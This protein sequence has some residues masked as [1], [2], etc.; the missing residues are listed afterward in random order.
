MVKKKL[1]IAVIAGES[2]GDLIASRL[3]KSLQEQYGAI[4]FF[5]V[6]GEKMKA[7][8]LLEIFPM[9]DINVMGLVEVIPHIIT[10]AKRLNQA[11]EF[12]LRERPDAVITVDAPGFNFRLAKKIR[13][14]NNAIKLIHY[15]APTVWAWKPGRAKKIAKIY[16]HLL[17]LFSF[18]PPYFT[19][20]GLS[21]TFV[22]HPLSEDDWQ[23][24]PFGKRTYFTLLPGSRIAEVEK[25][26]PL[27]KEV[28]LHFKTSGL[29]FVLP[30]VEHL[31]AQIENEVKT[32]GCDV[33]VICDEIQ[34]KNIFESSRIAL[35]ASG[36]VSLELACAKT[37]MVICYRVSKFTEILARLL[38]KTKYFCLVNI[39]N[40]ENVVA[41][42]LQEKCNVKEICDEVSHLLLKENAVA[43]VEKFSLTMEKIKPPSYLEKGSSFLAAQSVL[44]VVL[45]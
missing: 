32:W 31:K 42:L 13:K 21:T 22:G 43:Q 36:T 28:A 15:V 6:G 12:I 3:M 44:N 34:K 14:K 29:T 18:E 8:G 20:H 10:I 23:P 9:R 37:P 40:N 4:D 35:A 5:G 16:D 26:L 33:N 2:S 24:L 11:C 19:Q 39:L 38:I 30:T 7:L 17:T 41:E 27:F 25:L 1:K 45:K